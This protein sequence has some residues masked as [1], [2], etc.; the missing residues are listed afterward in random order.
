[1]KNNGSN[2]TKYIVSRD[3]CLD[4]GNKF[5]AAY[6]QALVVES[7]EK[8]SFSL[9]K[10]KNLERHK[11][12]F[13]N[14]LNEIFGF[15]DEEYY[16][17][18]YYEMLLSGKQIYLDGNEEE[19]LKCSRHFYCSNKEYVH[20]AYCLHMSI[21]LGMAD[22]NI[23]IAEI[24]IHNILKLLQIRYNVESKQY[25]KMKLHIIGEY[26][27]KFKKNEFL[28][29]F[30]SNYQYLK[31]YTLEYDSFFCM[32]LLAYTYYLAE[33]N[34]KEYDVWIGKCEENIE[35]N[36]ADKFYNF[37]QCK[38]AW[39]KARELRKQ[40]HNETAIELLE[41]TITNYLVTDGKNI[42]LFYGYVYLEATYN[43]FVIQDYEQMYKFAQEGIEICRNCEAVG[44]ELYYNLYNYFGVKLIKDNKLVAAGNL[45]KSCIKDIVHKFGKESENYILYISNLGI[46]ALIE[47]RNTDKYLTEIKQVKS[48]KLREKFIELQVNQLHWAWARGSSIIVIN[49]IYKS[50]MEDMQEEKYRKEREIAS[51]I[52]LI[53]RVNEHI[54]ND[55]TISLIE[56]LNVCYKDRAL[57][58]LSIAY[59][60]CVAVYKWENGKIHVALQ[61]FEKLMIEITEDKYEKYITT[62]MNHIQLLIVNKQYEKAKRYILIILDVFEKKILS[63]GFGN[64]TFCVFIIRMA[65]SMYIYILEIQW[66]NSKEDKSEMILL[67]EK[68]V[69]CKTIEREIKSLLSRYKEKDIQNDLYWYNQAHRKLATLELRMQLKGENKEDYERKRNECNWEMEEQQDILKKRIPFNDLIKP[70]QFKNIKIPSNSVCAEYFAYYKF[71]ENRPMMSQIR[72]KENEKLSEYI[73]FILD[74]SKEKILD[75]NFISFVEPIEIR[76]DCL[77]RAMEEN[78]GDNENGI[79]EIIK[80]FN[81]SLASPVLKYV[82]GK[83]NVYL[84]MDYLLQML[85]VDLIFYDCYEEPLKIIL[86][87]SIRYIKQDNLLD[88]KN[89]DALVIGNPQYNIDESYES[90]IPELRYS[91][92]EC[93]V[94]AKM[95]GIKPYT[96][97]MAR[98]NIL[99]GNYRK[100]IIH[101]STHGDLLLSMVEEASINTQ[102]FSSSWLMLA[103]YEDWK[104]DRKNIDYGNGIVTA[105]DFLF[106]DLSKTSLVVLSAC[107]S[108][109]GIIRGLESMHG[110]RWAI[111]TAGAKSS[112]TALWEVCDSVTAILMILFYRNLEKL[113]VGESLYEAKK[114]LRK[115]TVGELKK[116]NLFWDIVKENIA[117]I[118]NDD[119]KPFKHWKYWAGY[120][121]Y[122]G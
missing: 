14:L 6:F 101:I 54:F 10:K 34:D 33:K 113:S 108:N 37:L 96:G 115:I 95:L 43:C 119:Y 112:V 79:K 64:I 11:C 67:L 2:T 55:E 87:E 83:G 17:G 107:V 122:C 84:A 111:G 39:I 47:G 25:A 23:E 105:D 70:F 58:E 116:N 5:C 35:K 88:I 44:S 46:I 31:K 4:K 30:R 56:K 106:M 60:T 65:V 40:N 120:V 98:Q 19:C 32:S 16:K 9:N 36:K 73:V 3:N 69:N 99:W 21:I 93:E 13:Y 121:F 52:C 26:Y 22:S 57:D 27:F 114:I 118:E 104:E 117:D 75:I 45:Y 110:M 42:Q 48:K 7:I 20:E 78:Y 92:I 80:Y 74:D 63:I 59:W 85:P 41:K 103:G 49:R 89:A 86:M 38:L 8:S 77:L 82:C 91:Q 61:I 90:R 50:C 76:L 71:Y 29:L 100:G 81:E 94:I 12:I 97:K 15:Y 72:N 24:Y 51:T 18:I 66:K 68:I 53:A 109:L 28:N 1:M 102:V 62:V